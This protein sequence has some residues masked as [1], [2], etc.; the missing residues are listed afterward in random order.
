MRPLGQCPGA[1]R[2]DFR[3]VA[4]RRGTQGSLVSRE[5]AS[6]EGLCLAVKV[7]P[8]LCHKDTR[9]GVGVGLR[10]WVWAC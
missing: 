10:L 9:L 8:S 7:L 5:R 4:G 3:L 1:V 2:W 6:E